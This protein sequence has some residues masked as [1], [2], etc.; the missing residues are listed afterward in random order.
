VD[1]TSGDLRVGALVVS[2][3]ARLS[4]RERSELRAAAQ[5]QWD[6]S[7]GGWVQRQ[8]V[9]L[10]LASIIEARLLHVRQR[11]LDAFGLAKDPSVVTLRQMAALWRAHPGLAGQAFELAVADAVEQGVPEVVD[12]LREALRLLG[13]TAEGPLGMKVLGLEKVRSERRD[14]VVRELLYELPADAV[15]RTGRPGRPPRA[16]TVVERMSTASWAGM[17]QHVEDLPEVPAPMTRMRGQ[18]ELTRVSQLGRA[19]ALVYTSTDL[20]AASLK[21]NAM[22]VR[23]QSCGWRD[24]PLWVTRRADRDVRTSV[25]VIKDALVPMV[26]VS[27]GDNRWTDAFEEALEVLESTLRNLDLDLGRFGP[28]HPISRR[29]AQLADVPLLQLCQELRQVHEV[30]GEQFSGRLVVDSHDADLA[31]VG[32]GGLG[33]AWEVQADVGNVILGQRHL[34]LGPAS[35]LEPH[36]QSE[37]ATSALSRFPFGP[38]DVR[39]RVLLDEWS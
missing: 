20:F 27:Y 5:S 21:V 37:S 35:G 31:V 13:A 1:G 10:A 7:P 36:V 2:T 16:A 24:V 8:T 25:T 17:R 19:D 26:V 30:V 22:H 12:P 15:L 28:Q 32:G 29:L 18:D 33:R 23:R 3:P 14:A 39:D 4:P 11:R 6:L 9:R 34:F 38:T